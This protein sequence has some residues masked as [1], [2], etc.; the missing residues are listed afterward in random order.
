MP[1]H[2]LLAAALLLLLGR[3]TEATNVNPL[4]LLVS[5]DGF[6]HDLLNE[7][8]VPNIYKW[9]K[10]AVWFV[11]GS[12][13]QY[14]TFTAP[15]HMSIATGLY[16]E[17]HGIVSNFFFDHKDDKQFD[18]FNYTG[19]RSDKE[20]DSSWY[21]GEPIWLTNEKAG[22]SRKSA[23]LDWPMVEANF[24]MAPHH[25]KWFRA[26]KHRGNLTTWIEDIDT[27]LEQFLDY[28][29]NFGAFYL[30]EPD[31]VLHE[32]GFYNGEFNKTIQQ[33]D[34]AFDYLIY[35][36]K[37]LNLEDR[38]NIIL[39]ADHGHAQIQGYK[40][41]FC[42]RDY[43]L[44]T[45]FEMGDHMIYPTDDD[46]ANEVFK[47]LTR[48]K[49]EGYKIEVLWKKD[50]SPDLHYKNSS[51]VG[52]III[53]PTIGSG[54]SFSCSQKEYEKEYGPN[55]TK[56]F[57]SSTHGMDPKRPEMRALLA[58]RGPAFES[59]KMITEIP[60]NIDIY[61]LI[62]SIL[63]IT[64]APNNGSLAI[65]KKAL[66]SQAN[67]AEATTS[68][69]DRPLFPSDGPIGHSMFYIGF[70]DSLGFL[71]I[72]V[73]SLC[74]VLLIFGLM[75]RNTVLKNDPNWTRPEATRGYRPLSFGNAEEDEE[76]DF[77]VLFSRRN[78]PSGELNVTSSKK[79]KDKEDTNVLLD[80]GSSSDEDVI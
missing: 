28:G 37:A 18:Y 34:K 62:C 60:T 3:L 35:R 30:A 14:V 65:I 44:G 36:A 42:I 39:T 75:C 52:Q 6:R 13:S 64:P 5:F 69:T 55:G 26:W 17:N 66:K 53:N 73:P 78:N 25:P 51:R 29:V 9:A 77:Q 47:N 56:T 22:D 8:T 67:A 57:H 48:A 2:G 72:L 4:V 33:V 58:M 68:G 54:L 10:E 23:V 61:P 59:R 41:V 19:R 24:P 21:L 32:N 63:K 31:S 15:N 27:M 46:H 12:Q 20:M 7:T 11:N 49:E 76:E 71:V 74:I 1:R 50:L 38:L 45:G 40:S 79:N 16:E 70:T 43:V 80:V